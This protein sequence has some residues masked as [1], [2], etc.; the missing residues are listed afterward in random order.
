M[1]RDRSTTDSSRRQLLKATG[2]SIG[3]GGLAGCLQTVQRIQREDGGQTDAA[4][5]GNGGAEV[6]AKQESGKTVYWVLPGP[7]RLSETV[8]GTPDNPKSTVQPAIK[9]AK[10]E[11]IK[12]LLRDFPIAVGLP[13]DKRATNEDGTKFT[14]S[15]IPTPFGDK[16]RIIDGEFDITYVDR[17]NGQNDGQTSDELTVNSVQFTDP[18]QNSYELR[19]KKLF[20]PP[21]PGWETDG[22]VTTDTFLHGLT[23]TGSPL[24]AKL[25][26]YGASWSVGDIVANGDVVDENKVIHWMTTQV[27][28]DK[29]YRLAIDEELPLAKENTIAGQFHHTHLIIQPVTITDSGP[30]Y[31]PLSIPFTLPNGNSQPFIHVMYEQDTVDAPFEPQFEMPAEKD[32]TTPTETPQEAVEVRGREYAFNPA[33]I[34]VQQGEQTT[35]QFRNTGTIAHNFTLSAFDAQTPTIQPGNSATVTFTPGE[36]G[37]FTY[38]CSVPG[39]A[40]R[41]MQ[42]T[43]IVE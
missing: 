35:I 4:V 2:A 6:S 16:G 41:G 1:T 23:G 20:E 37:E 7:R 26:T 5:S 27:V 33:E 13:V 19:F 43:L 36:T 31:E 32:E 39:H 14:Q 12:Q 30:K 29:N 28:R 15:T 17:T 8:F 9:K 18:A 11:P 25:Y 22:G 42:G 21:I 40:Q 38:I 24:M 10:K 34:T 3:V